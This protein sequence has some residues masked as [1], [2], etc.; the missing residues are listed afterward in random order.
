MFFSR[1]LKNL[2]LR[3]IPA[4]NHTWKII[5]EKVVDTFF[6]KLGV[7]TQQIGGLNLPDN[8]DTLGVKIFI[9]TM[10]LESWTVQTA[11]VKIKLINRTV[12]LLKVQVLTKFCKIHAS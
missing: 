12:N 11:V 10:K 7:K 1:L 6:P 4:D 5:G 2:C 9:I 8:L 3:Q